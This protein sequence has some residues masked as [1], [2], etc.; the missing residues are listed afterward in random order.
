MVGSEYCEQLLSQMKE[1]NVSTWAAGPQKPT[2]PSLLYL[3]LSVPN[4]LP[5]HAFRQRVTH[6]FVTVVWGPRYYL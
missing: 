4:P 2:T 1:S 3:H 6:G 5:Q